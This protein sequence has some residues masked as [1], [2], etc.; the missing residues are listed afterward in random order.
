MSDGT[1]KPAWL[2]EAGITPV[3][4][5]SMPKPSAHIHGAG[6]ISS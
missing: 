6:A 4:A 1:Q 3:F 5:L 2:A